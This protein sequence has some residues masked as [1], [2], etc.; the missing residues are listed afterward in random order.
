MERKL[1]ALVELLHE[2]DD[3]LD[4][5][6]ILRA[7]CLDPNIDD[8]PTDEFTLWGIADMVED[9]IERRKNNG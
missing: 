7:S 5:E 8:P 6:I 9:Y 3:E 2:L 1:R 4:N